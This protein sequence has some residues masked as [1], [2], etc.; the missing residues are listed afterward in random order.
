MSGRYQGLVR[1]RDNK[2]TATGKTARAAP[3][4][5]APHIF[6]LSLHRV[7]HAGAGRRGSAR[8]EIAHAHDSWGGSS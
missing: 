7:R 1:R 4:R 8:H 2:K 5:I 3:T 6:I